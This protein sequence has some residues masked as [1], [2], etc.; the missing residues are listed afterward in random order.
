MLSTIN[1]PEKLPRL[2]RRSMNPAVDVKKAITIH[3]REEFATCIQRTDLVSVSTRS[4]NVCHPSAPA[5]IAL[6]TVAV[7]NSEENIAASAFSR[8]SW[9]T[10]FTV[11]SIPAPL[12]K[13]NNPRR[14]GRL[15]ITMPPI[16]FGSMIPNPKIASTRPSGIMNRARHFGSS[17]ALTM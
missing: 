8:I 4:S 12:A 3:A 14:S 10:R 2:R 5:K 15:P 7:H 16:S 11:V 17:N 13:M 1:E 6:K 9:M